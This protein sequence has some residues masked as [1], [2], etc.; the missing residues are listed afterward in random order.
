M[1]SSR[2]LFISHDANRAGS[3]L[4]L[5]QL[6]SLLS[7]RG[8][9]SHLLL[10]GGGELEDDFRKITPVTLAYTTPKSG[11]KRYLKRILS[12]L[13]YG[14][15]LLKEQT[16]TPEREL[17][18]LGIGLVFVNS[19]ANSEYYHKNL[20]FLHHLPVVLFAHELEMSVSIYTKEDSL[21]FLLRKCA[22]L[23]AVSQAVANFY[24]TKYLYPASQVSTFTLINTDEISSKLKDVDRHYLEQFHAIPP[25]ALVIGGCGNAEWR[26]GNDIFNLIAR[27]VITSLPDVLIYFVWVGAGSMHPIFDLIKFDL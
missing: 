13:P 9:S 17:R 19:I 4:L 10:C 26:K 23:I 24:C 14:K 3:Q 27:E 16:L 25:D 18:Q 8:V 20:K 15:G 12:K 22:H 7:H 21:Q 1:S 2:V 6:I 11:L 5:L